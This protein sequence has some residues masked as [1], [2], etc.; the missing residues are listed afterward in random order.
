[1]KNW[2]QESA[3]QRIVEAVQEHFVTP[4]GL[5]ALADAALNGS[6]PA[7]VMAVNGL[8]AL[9]SRPERAQEGRKALIACAGDSSKQVQGA[10]EADH[11]SPTRTGSRTISPCSK[12]GRAPREVL[13]C[14]HWPGSA[15]SSTAPSFR[16]ALTV[17][18]NSKL[19]DQLTSILG[20]PRPEPERAPPRPSPRPSWPFQVLKG[21]KKRKVQWLLDQPLPA[22]RRTDGGSHRSF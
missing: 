15:W 7:R 12:A 1:M 18:K 3:K 10:A 19:I 5:D 13:P 16:E 17:E 6:A 21:G 4:E 11:I 14:R 9:A 22:V 2:Y 8:D 20:T